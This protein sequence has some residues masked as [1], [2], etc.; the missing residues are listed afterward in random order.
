MSQRPLASDLAPGDGRASFNRSRATFGGLQTRIRARAR[1]VKFFTE[2]TGFSPIN[3][4]RRKDG[5]NARPTL[6]LRPLAKGCCEMAMNACWPMDF[7]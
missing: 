1:L 4:W 6:Q 2:K 5:R 3:G 7:A